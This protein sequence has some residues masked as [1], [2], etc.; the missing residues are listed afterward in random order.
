MEPSVYPISV[1]HGDRA[2]SL[3]PFPLTG[4][5]SMRRHGPM[6]YDPPNAL[7]IHV[8]LADIDPPVWRRL[9]VPMGWRLDQLHLAIQA[10][11]NWWNYHL[12]QFRIGGLSYGDVEI[13][14]V[15]FEDDPRMLDERSV[16]LRDFSLEPAPRFDYVYDFGD[17][18]VHL[19]EIEKPLALDPAPKQASCIAGA[20]ARPP[21]DVGGAD[22]YQRFLEIMADRDDPEHRDTKRWCGG[23]F[24]PAWFDLAMVDRDVKNALRKNARRRLHQPKPQRGA[25]KA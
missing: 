2:G 16:R 21:E 7:Q 24:D 14:D 25:P 5:A 10:A 11:F 8:V 1:D 23:H 4:P 17:H 3:A 15:G 19:V 22:G 12:H 6:S 18:W 13:E 20:N 9:V